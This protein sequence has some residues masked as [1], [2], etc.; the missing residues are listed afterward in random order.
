[1]LRGAGRL[2]GPGRVTVGDGTYT[3]T[4]VVIATG[5]EPVIPPVPGLR[6]LDDVWTNREATGLTEVPRRLLILGGGAVG[7]ELGQA[8][9]RMGASVAI[10][11]G[12]PAHPFPP[13]VASDDRI[14]MRDL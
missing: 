10:V 12:A 14:A 11:R 9:A 4:D 3:A 8:F 13:P 5:S 7:L 6:E 2:A 1:V